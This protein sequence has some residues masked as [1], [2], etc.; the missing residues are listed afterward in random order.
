MSR[1]VSPH[2]TIWGSR[3]AIALVAALAVGL[4]RH[5]LV[6]WTHIAIPGFALAYSAGL[7]V[8]VFADLAAALLTALFFFAFAVWLVFRPMLLA[9]TPSATVLVQVA[10]FVA[11]SIFII[12]VGYFFRRNQKRLIQ[13][14]WI[15][16]Q[17]ESSRRFA[18]AVS[19]MTEAIFIT[20]AS[21]N[22][23]HFNPAFA[24]FNRIKKNDATLRDVAAL[25]PLIEI[26]PL[27]GEPLPPAQWPAAR[28]LR[29]ESGSGEIYNH[30]RTD[31]GE[32]WSGV[33]NFSP[34]RD[35]SGL[36]TGAIVSARD[37]T[38]QLEAE[39]ALLA[40]DLRYR[41]AF[42]TS[43]DGIVIFLLEDGR[44][45]EVN[46]A[47]V[48]LTGWDREEMIGRSF[49][50]LN[51]FS[52]PAD[53]QM[54]LDILARDG[55]FR[56]IEVALRRKNGELFRGLFS[57]SV[58]DVDGVL[59][60]HAT[61]RDVTELRQK[62]AALK[63]S[64]TRYHAA[65]HTIFDAIT[66][67][68]LETRTILDVNDRI[69]QVTGYTRAD[70]VGRQAGCF[71][72]W[73]DDRDRVL[74]TGLLRDHGSFSDR[75]VRLRRKS[76]EIF[77]TTMSGAI[78]DIDGRN[79]IFIA[80]RDITEKHLAE[81]ALRA[82]ETRY[83]TVF[84]ASLDAIVIMKTC[85]W[86]FVDASQAYSNLTGWTREEI[87]GS[88]G[89][90]LG[91]WKDPDRQADAIAIQR[92]GENLVNFP[93]EFRKKNGETIHVLIST[94][95]IVVQDEPCVLSILRDISDAKRAEHEIH[96]LSYF[97]PLTGLA[98]RRLLDERLT[99]YLDACAGDNRHIALL[100]IDLDNFQTI[101]NAL[102]HAA[103][104]ALLRV[105]A[106]RLS[107]TVRTSDIVARAGGDEFLVLLDGLDSSRETA[108]EQVRTVALK[109]NAAVEAPIPIE[110]HDTI[111]TCSVGI[112]LANS[113]PRSNRELFQ[114]ADI[115]MHQAKDAGRNTFR[116][117]S[118]DLQ[119]A[120][121]ARASIEEDLH[122][123][124]Q[125]EQFALLYQPQVERGR[126]VGAE[127]L[128]R[129]QHPQLGTLPPDRFIPIAEQT[130]L[131]LP[132]GNWVLQTACRQIAQWSAAHPE[133]NLSVSVNISALQ[134]RQQD[135]VQSVL[136]VVRAAGA[137]PHR[138]KLEL[139]ESMLAEN[140]EDT[141]AKMTALKIEGISFSLDDFGT[142]YSSLAYLRRLPLGQLKIDRSF[143]S[144]ILT[145]PG[146]AAIAQTI[147]SLS[148]A[149][150]VPVVAEGVETAEQRACLSG[151]GCHTYQGYLFSRPIPAAEFERLLD[152]GGK[153]LPS[154]NSAW[155]SP[156]TKG[157]SGA[158]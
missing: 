143:V 1:K 23:T 150:G 155:E 8:A 48:R 95:P 59:C 114:Q 5:L 47:F 116:I 146:S 148:H 121:N 60:A 110:G 85:D 97:D 40:S 124:L 51:L 105:V 117:F 71:N 61:L 73:A 107:D 127:A 101:N 106:H 126:I 65:F 104:D 16:A 157:P 25:R 132:I 15:A 39:T 35:D 147:I 70:V 149:L 32:T 30:R 137:D 91:L 6:T 153:L 109:I 12:L 108:A 79:C 89:E 136:A 72:F 50:D 22:I 37:I 18:A 86:S 52:D 154:S 33:F 13:H 81:E 80:I 49:P 17:A 94:T 125:D 46:Q 3:L 142:G 118:P 69:T 141:I 55:Q 66:I 77:Q 92:R 43:Q 133:R 156:R 27:G 54:L 75:A 134:L 120:I 139:T 100:A 83:R 90:K 24:I 140:I 26:S 56:E 42:E 14:E 29:G 93:A 130:R 41:T 129:W 34:I 11:T 63:A 10:L 113:S 58:M 2:L 88:T 82:S 103:G 53:R 144:D 87:V 20:D 158:Q 122:R 19:S 99:Q 84:Q 67:T 111:C 57:A 28:A 31:T 68:D 62:E 135:F 78:V 74:L 96:Q 102:G 131:I 138:L 76:G 9:G 38:A 112:T 123:A 45:I 4:V 64:E 44:Y 115:A 128:I 36:I 119:D 98:N 145:E 21:G 151:M 152:A 7:A